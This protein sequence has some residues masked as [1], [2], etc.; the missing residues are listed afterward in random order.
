MKGYRISNPELRARFEHHEKA[1]LDSVRIEIAM[2]RAM[3]EDRLEM[4]GD[5]QAEKIAA[6]Q[7]VTPT[8]VNL[9]KCVETL[10]KLE[11]QNS[12]VLG[13][14][15]LANLGKEIIK[16]ITEELEGVPNHDSIVDSVASRIATAIAETRNQE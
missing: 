5:N 16:V 7:S 12:V 4:V 13:K 14:E 6:F 10:S 1:S 8:L 15:A 2:L 11:R 3:I 9:V